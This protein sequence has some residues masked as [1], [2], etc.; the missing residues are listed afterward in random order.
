MKAYLDIETSYSSDITIIGIF[1]ADGRVRQLIGDEITCENLLES[2]NGIETIITYNG[3]R[4]DL[5]VISHLKKKSC[6]AC[7]N[8][9]QAASFTSFSLGIFCFLIVYQITFTLLSK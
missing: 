2:L 6:F 3:S 7:L 8:H 5:P 1:Y 9:F 4:F